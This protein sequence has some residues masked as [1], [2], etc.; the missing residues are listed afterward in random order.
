DKGAY[1]YNGRVKALA[2]SCREAGLQF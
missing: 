2:E 1:V